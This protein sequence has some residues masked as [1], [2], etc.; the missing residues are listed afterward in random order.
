[1]AIVC[2]DTHI[3]VWSIL[4]QGTDDGQLLEH[5]AGF[6]LW[7]EER[8]SKVIIPTIVLGEMLVAVPD[9]DR[10]AV[11]AQ[12]NKDWMIVDY[13]LRA[14]SIF[15]QMRRDH[16][17]NKRFK[18]LRKLNPDVTR[19][20]LGADVMIIAT[21]RSYGA[22]IIYS[23]DQNLLALAEGWIPAADFLDVS[24]QLKLL[25]APEDE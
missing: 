14:A 18:D 9:E 20:E 1:M 24:V 6:M 15:A 16:I 5:A 10:P 7:L 4:E 21:A 17:R 11:L 23:H 13:D 2:V 25:E 12:F 22:D 8:D 19:K 3:L